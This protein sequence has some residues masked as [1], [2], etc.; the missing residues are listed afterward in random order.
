MTRHRALLIAGFMIAGP[1]LRAP[2]FAQVGHTPAASP[3]IDLEHSQS[4]TLIG[5][6]YHAHRDP[7]DVGPQ[8]GFLTGLQNHI[9][10]NSLNFT[11]FKINVKRHQ[12]NA[13]VLNF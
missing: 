2:A 11:G 9:H 13:V 10:R 8:S 12:V 6:Q 5:G 3:Y 7:A 4:L 1:A